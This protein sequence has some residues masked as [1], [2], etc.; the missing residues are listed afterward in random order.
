M[1]GE[2][3]GQGLC[4]SGL[5]ACPHPSC[6]QRCLWHKPHAVAFRTCRLES[7]PCMNGG[8]S[9]KRCGSK[10]VV[11]PV[12]WGVHAMPHA[13]SGGAAWCCNA[14][15]M[16]LHMICLSAACH[17]S[18]SC[19]C[20][21]AGHSDLRHAAPCCA[22]LHHAAPCCAAHAHPGHEGEGCDGPAVAALHRSGAAIP[23]RGFEGHARR[24]G[25][26]SNE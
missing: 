7:Q 12:L 6:Q 3:L 11:A 16:P 24:E 23:R 21:T 14:R 18:A 9:H 20:P 10:P 22:M 4:C 1:L 15:W 19:L 2:Q 17:G 8:R 25:L 26:H 13:G 5:R